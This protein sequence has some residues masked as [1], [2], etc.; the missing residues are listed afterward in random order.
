[1]DTLELCNGAF[2][3]Q[4]VKGEN[5]KSTWQYTPNVVKLQKKKKKAVHRDVKEKPQYAI[6][7]T[8][9][10]A[11]VKRFQNVATSIVLDTTKYLKSLIK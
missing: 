10:D 5:G 3:A 2:T 6:I 1:M 7:V 9:E 4:L 8:M 11:A